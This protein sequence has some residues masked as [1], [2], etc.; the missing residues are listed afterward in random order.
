SPS[1]IR[2]NRIEPSQM[3]SPSPGPSRTSPMLAH[4]FAEIERTAERAVV[5]LARM[6]AIDT[7]FPPGAGYDAFA[8][9]M[10]S[11]VAALGLECRRVEVPVPLWRVTGSPAHGRRTNL[12]ARRRSGKPVLGLYFHVDT[13]PA[14]PG[15]TTDPFTLTR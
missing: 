3:V 4:G 6:V 10:E 5:D 12:I 15:W 1:A 8:E 7:T 2:F 9:L 11:T 14:G 13:V